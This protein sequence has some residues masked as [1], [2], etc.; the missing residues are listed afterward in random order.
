VLWARFLWLRI[1]STGYFEQGSELSD[2]IKYSEFL[3]SSAIGCF[4][5][6]TKLHGVRYD[7]LIITN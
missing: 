3:R 2:S 7:N 1:S 4:S 5:R 6:R